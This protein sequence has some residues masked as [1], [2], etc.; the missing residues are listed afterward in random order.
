M[1]GTS[2]QL[3]AATFQKLESSFAQLATSPG[4]GSGGG[5]GSG[6]L[7]KLGINP[8]RWLV[9]PSVQGSAKTVAGASTT[10]IRAGVNVS[11]RFRF[12]F[13]KAM[14]CIAIHGATDL[15]APVLKIDIVPA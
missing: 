14:T 12:G 11:A 5:S 15:E 4:G 6:A 7:G 8:L 9:N 3:P 1:Q 2:Y 13:D 10:H